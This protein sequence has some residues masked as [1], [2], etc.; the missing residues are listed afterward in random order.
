M[1]TF[2]LMIK[3]NNIQLVTEKITY[4]KNTSKIFTEGKTN[5]DI[6]NKYKFKSKNLTFLKDE[7]EIIFIR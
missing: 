3:K 5:A 7:N 2:I 4:K 6:K 1:V